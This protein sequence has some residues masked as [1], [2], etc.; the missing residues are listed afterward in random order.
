MRQQFDMFARE[1]YWAEKVPR[2]IQMQ[3][4]I[5]LCRLLLWKGH[6]GMFE[7]QLPPQL[8]L[9][10]VV[11]WSKGVYVRLST[12][13][14]WSIVRG[15]HLVRECDVSEWRSVH[16]RSKQLHVPVWQLFQRL[17]LWNQGRRAN[18][19]G[20][21][22]SLSFCGRDRVHFDLHFN[23]SLI[24]RSQ[25]HISPRANGNGRGQGWAEAELHA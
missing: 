2:K 3:L 8:N 21:F 1:K 24:G 18:C 20:E 17:A 9:H 25:V 16:W 6:T 5:W 4:W 13:I 7:L 15:E 23:C 11:H 22:L 12:G 10:S 14:Q 19:V